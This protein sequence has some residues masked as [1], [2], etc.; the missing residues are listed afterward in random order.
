[1]LVSVSNNM[2]NEFVLENAVQKGIISEDSRDRIVKYSTR[3]QENNVPVIFNLR[4]LRKICNINKKEQNL[5]FG[6]HREQLYRQ[7]Y[8]PKKSGGIRKI[9][10]PDDKLKAIQRWIKNDILDSF[11]SSE[12]ATGFKKGKSIVDNARQHIGKELIVNIDLKDFFPSI[13]YADVVR[14]FSYMGYRID[15]A[16][17]LTKLCTN[18][19]NVLPQGSPASPALS[20]LVSLRLDKRLGQLAKSLNCTYSRYADDITFSG[21]KGIR[22]ALPLIR[23]II[24]DEGFEINEDKVRLQY[25]HQRQEVTGLIVNKKLSVSPRI[26]REL[27]AAIFFCKKY[28]VSDHMKHIGCDKHFYKEHLYGLAYFV[29][30]VDKDLGR[31]YLSELDSIFWG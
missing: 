4:H 19:K 5:Y 14:I 21:K 28:S 3:L 7:F 12:H 6:I 22:S 18:G 29:N 13:H 15:V 24:N 17:L 20:N 27:N 16:H 11:S 8:I 23:E 26:K 30:M 25:A 1:M 10:A 9:E 31:K 2:V